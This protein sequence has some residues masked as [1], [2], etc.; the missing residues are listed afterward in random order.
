M[1]AKFNW[2]AKLPVDFTDRWLEIV[3]LL[4]EA[5]VIPIPRWIG[6]D[7]YSILSLHAFTDSSDKAIGTVVYLVSPKSSVFIS[8]KA[9]VFPLK[10]SHF[11]VPRKELTGIAVG[12]RHIMFVSKALSKYINIE[13]HHI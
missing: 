9:K 6:I 12:A 7:L 3:D 4:K 5:L 13:S 2:D 1:E 8:S 11:T 10:M